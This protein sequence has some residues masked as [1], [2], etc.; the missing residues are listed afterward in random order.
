M[1]KLG[2][3]A[4]H[5]DHVAREWTL[6]GYSN[7]LL[8]EHKKKTYL[9]L[10]ARW[11]DVANARN[12]LKTDLFQEASGPDQFLFDLGQVEQ[13]RNRHRCFQRNS[14]PGEK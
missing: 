7:E 13:Q 4:E 8:A 2:S 12:I 10:I 14:R 5:W 6:K 1:S 9:G 3:K 11:A